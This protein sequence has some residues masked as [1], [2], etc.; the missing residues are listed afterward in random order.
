MIN[1]KFLDIYYGHDDSIFLD[2][3]PCEYIEKTDNE[4]L[5][6]L[7]IDAAYQVEVIRTCDFNVAIFVRIIAKD[8]LDEIKIEGEFYKINRV[9]QEL[10]DIQICVVMKNE[11]HRLNSFL[12]F[13]RKVHNISRFIIYDNQS[14]EPAPMEFQSDPELVIIKWDIPYNLALSSPIAS[15]PLD[16]T[17]AAQNSAYSNCLKK[18]HHSQWTL[19]VDLD[20][21]IVCKESKNNLLDLTRLLP[22]LVDTI[23][24]TGFWA[25]CNGMQDEAITNE[26]DKIIL[27]SSE[28]CANKLMLRTRQH[29]FTR[30]IHWPYPSLRGGN[31]ILPDPSNSFYFLHLWTASTKRR[32]CECWKYCS[33]LD[34]TLSNSVKA[35]NVPCT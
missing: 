9:S 19:L 24:F 32:T 22:N 31:Q 8:G 21:F 18:Y 20:E 29:Y 6:A 4:I 34:M 25:G 16:W 5:A 15:P 23:I 13:Y 27:R 7:N 10:V 1:N 14:D 3:N 35:F 26:L 11:W 12:R 2:L 28:N 17:I 33:M 30:S